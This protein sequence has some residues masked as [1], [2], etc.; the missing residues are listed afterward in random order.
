[1]AA[2]GRLDSRNGE[3]IRAHALCNAAVVTK[4]WKNNI[5]E[6]E[7]KKDNNYNGWKI[8]IRS[9][10]MKKRVRRRRT[11]LKIYGM[12]QW[13]RKE[14]YEKKLWMRWYYK[15]CTIAMCYNKHWA[16]ATK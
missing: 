7:K 16:F 1:M 4:I 11:S 10:K 6:E 14:T 12:K 13:V 15:R 3:P 9:K 5:K 2:S 8:R